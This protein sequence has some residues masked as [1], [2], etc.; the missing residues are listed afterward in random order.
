MFCETEIDKAINYYRKALDNKENI[1]IKPEILINLGNAYNS[2]GRS[3]EALEKY[4]EAL[5]LNPNHPMALGNKALALKY[6]AHLMQDDWQLFYYEAYKLLE[7][8]VANNPY[9]EAKEKFNSERQKLSKY[10]NKLKEFPNFITDNYLSD[11]SKEKSLILFCLKNKLYLNLCN[12]CQKCKVAIGDN[13][14]IRK[15]ITPIRTKDV[16]NALEDDIFLQLSSLLNQIKQDYVSARF[17]LFTS[18]TKNLDLK[19][20]D[21]KVRL[22]DTLNYEVNNIY[23]QFAKISFKI[24]FD[25]LDKIALFIC[26]YLNLEIDEDKVNFYNVWFNNSNKRFCINDKIKNT[27]NY[28]LNAIYTLKKDLSKNKEGS[29]YFY[30]LRNTRNALT[31]RYFAIVLYATNR[32]DCLMINDFLNQTIEIA[33]IVRSVVVYLLSFVDETENKKNSASKGLLA[34]MYTSD[35]KDEFK[36]FE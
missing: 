10:V 2:V 12:P 13:L 24:F 30:Y 1:E 22:I 11:N 14:V 25:I 8:A 17:L 26:K 18:I 15:M 4:E 16:N 3:L 34:P 7:K 31:H 33:K 5:N 21:K 20:V 19:Y 29:G 27:K 6:Y 28:S 9:K 36:Y 32:I 23:I 35:I